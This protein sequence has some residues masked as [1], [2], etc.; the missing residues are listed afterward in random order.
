MPNRLVT[1]VDRARS[2]PRLLEVTSREVEKKLICIACR[3]VPDREAYRARWVKAHPLPRRWCRTALHT[4]GPY[5]P[6]IDRPT[7]H[8][9]W[10]LESY[11]NDNMPA[12]EAYALAFKCPD[13][14]GRLHEVSW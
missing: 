3:R 8:K 7:D 11:V 6:F 13:C 2:S 4:K 9:R 10:H 5:A 12:F 1:A 14:G